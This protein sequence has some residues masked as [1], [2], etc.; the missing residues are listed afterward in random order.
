M[1]V[2]AHA[3]RVGKPASP[4]RIGIDVCPSLERRLELADLMRWPWCEMGVGR[5]RFATLIC[6]QPFAHHLP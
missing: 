2:Q 1:M 4:S 3:L 6:P 5:S